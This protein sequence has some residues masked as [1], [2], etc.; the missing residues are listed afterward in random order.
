[1]AVAMNRTA[2]PGAWSDETSE[3]SAES[4][5]A[6]SHLDHCFCCC[7]HLLVALSPRFDYTLSR[8]EIPAET[9]EFL[10]RGTAAPV[11]HPPRLA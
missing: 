4:N 9:Q 5:M 7:R 6:S 2:L 10:P 1:M 8:P 11:F 3:D